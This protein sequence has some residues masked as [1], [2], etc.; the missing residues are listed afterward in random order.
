[1]PSPLEKAHHGQYRFQL[2]LRADKMRALSQHIH[3]VIHGMTFQQ[4]E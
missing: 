2:L 1:M 3:R 4:G